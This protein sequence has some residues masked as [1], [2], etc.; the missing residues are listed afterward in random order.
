MARRFSKN[1]GPNFFN[2]ILICFYIKIILMKLKKI[3]WRLII[4][5]SF[6]AGIV[7]LMVWQFLLVK[8]INLNLSFNAEPENNLPQKLS[9]P[10][11]IIK[12]IYITAST[13]GS[14]TR[15][16]E[17]IDLIK[18]TE[19]NAIVVDIK[20]YSGYVLYDSK[21]PIVESLGSQKAIIKDLNKLINTLHD[22]NIYVIAR[23]SVFQDPI[24][25]QKRPDLAVQSKKSGTT[26]KDRK[27]LSWVDPTAP[28]V[29]N[30]IISIALEANRRGFDELNFDYIRF[31]SDGALSDMVF[32][33]YDETKSKSEALEDFFSYLSSNLRFKNIKI[34]A[35]LFGLT[36]VDAGDLGIGQ[37]LEVAAQYFDYL[38]PMVYP[39]HYANG[40]LGFSNPAE[41]PYEI[42]KD[43]MENAQKRLDVLDLK[44]NSVTTT[45]TEEVVSSASQ[46]KVAKLRPWLQDFDLGAD[47]TENMIRL[48]KKAV[49]DVLL[50]DD[51]V[52]WLFWD[53][54]N[55]YTSSAFDPQQN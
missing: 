24:L 16:K 1:D 18:N 20:D 6:L 14:E 32:P 25:A 53:P 46:S 10:P 34:S 41:H 11:E 55:I 30:Y 9:N 7:G 5:I 49:S 19:L 8:E 4:V 50:G 37:K 43:S 54:K 29:W 39:S 44:L 42:V 31:P 47:Y 38:C 22:E 3:N 35:D 45:T 26:W 12:A 48:Q 27:G 36:T 15:L 40:F 23:I 28:E 51:F 2:W 17:I 33:Y 21:A 13:A 52:G